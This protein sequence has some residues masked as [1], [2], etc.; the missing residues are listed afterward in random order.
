MLH[1]RPASA[2]TRARSMFPRLSVQ[3]VLVLFL[4]VSWMA[5]AEA[6][7]PH[8]LVRDVIYNELQASKNDHSRWMYL[9]ADKTP[10][11]NQVKLVVETSDGTVSKLI[12]INGRPPNAQE[13]ALD[14]AKREKFVSD[15]S[16]RDKQRK[17]SAQDDKQAVSLM[18]MLPDAFIWTEAGKSNGDVILHFTPNPAFDPPT[19]ASRVFA[20]M[21][22]EMVVDAQ[23]KRLKILSGTLVRPVEFGWGLFGKLKQGGTFRVVHTRVA[24]HVW[25]ITQ[26]QVHI[27]GHILFFKSISEQQDEVTS[28]YKPTPPSLTLRQAADML[29]DGTIARDLGISREK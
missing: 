8:Q 25:Q 15:P 11:K 7:S 23:E 29:N 20:A 5:R 21:A 9:D 4:C 16:E 26:T 28:H 14:Q 6:S 17:N 24:P 1:F 10:A 19:Y 27:D 12:E 3:C 18:K 2:G 22:G 13:Q